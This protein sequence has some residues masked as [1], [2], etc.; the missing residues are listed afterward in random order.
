[1]KHGVYITFDVECSMGGA[2]ARKELRPVPPSRAMLGEYGRRRMGTPLITEILNDNGLA[3][4]FFVDPFAQEQG[5]P[6]Q[7]QGVVEALLRGGQ[8]VQLHIHPCNRYYELFRQGK[9]FPP[10]DEL[11][12]LTP[13]Q[14]SDLLGEGSR[15][16][17][18]WTGRRP[19]AFRAGNM[20]ASERTLPQ[21]A[22]AGLRIDS[23]YTFP[24]AG[25]QCRFGPSEPYNGSR[26]YG[27]VLEVALSGFLQPRLPGLRA[28]KP[29]DLMGVSFEECREAIQRICRAGADA[30]LILHSFSLFK[31]RNVQYD[32]GRPNRIV[33]RRLR[34]L[35][36]WL[37][38]HS[39]EFPVHTFGGLSRSVAQGEYQAQAVPPCR[40]SSPVRAVV[41]KLVQ[42][43]NHPYWT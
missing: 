13:A 19:T 8:D 9:P 41:R 24:F 34:R 23:S 14:Q 29:L 40:L 12:D 16:L 15:R 37:A 10:T 4:T 6:G 22:E 28:S 21:L 17:E 33:T 30:V 3:A 5:Y 27:K 39:A 7:T 36:R 18:A 25:G 2:Y 31:V 32:G 26:W 42:V 35:C 11:D 1:M 43:Y 38:D 20:A